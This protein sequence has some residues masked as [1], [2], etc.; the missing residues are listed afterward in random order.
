MDIIQQRIE[1]IVKA[2]GRPI[3]TGD[4]GRELIGYE[5]RGDDEVLVPARALSGLEGPATQPSPDGGDD[6]EA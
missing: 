5:P 3:L 1:T 4:E 2:V 6:L